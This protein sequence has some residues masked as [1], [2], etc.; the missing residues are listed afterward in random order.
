MMM[1]MMMSGAHLGSS[2]TNRSV[3]LPISNCAFINILRTASTS[4]ARMADFHVAL[5]MMGFVAAVSS[6][7]A[8]MQ[9]MQMQQ[10]GVLHGS[11]IWM[12]QQGCHT[13]VEGDEC[14]DKVMWA[15]R[16]GI[17]QHPE[18]YLPLTR[19]S[20]FEDFQQHLHGTARL[21]GVCPKPCAAA[22]PKSQ[23]RAEQQVGTPAPTVI[24]L[25]DL[26]VSTY[27]GY[28]QSGQNC[29][30]GA[31]IKAY[32]EEFET[33]ELCASECSLYPNCKSIGLH[34]FLSVWKG[35]CYLYD[36]ECGS[37]NGHDS[38]TTCA[39]PIPQGALSVNFNRIPTPAP[40]PAPTSSVEPCD[41]T[42]GSSPSSFYPCQCGPDMCVTNEVCS[43]D[44]RGF[45]CSPPGILKVEWPCLT[46]S[47]G[48][49]YF[50]FYGSSASGA[51]V[52]SNTDGNYIYWDYSC[53]GI[54]RPLKYAQ[55]RWILDSEEPNMTATMDLDSD[56]GCAYFG[57]HGSSDSNGVP[58]GNTTW[59]VA[60]DGQGLNMTVTITY[61][62]ILPTPSPTMEPGAPC[63]CDDACGSFSYLDLDGDEC[64]VEAEVNKD[65]NLNGHFT[66]M[67][68]NGD[69]CVTQAEC[70][71]SPYSKDMSRFPI[72]GPAEC[73]YG[74]YFLEGT[75]VCQQCTTGSTRRRRSEACTDCAPGKED[76]GDFDN[77][78]SGVWLTEPIST[79]S[80]VVFVNKA[81]DD[82]GRVLQ[83]GDG[84][85]M[86]TRNPGHFERLVITDKIGF[87]DSERLSPYH[88]SLLRRGGPFF[89][90][91]HGVHAGFNKYDAIVSACSSTNGVGLS[92]QYP[93]GCGI[94]ICDFGYRC[95]E[96]CAGSNT[97]IDPYLGSGFGDG[98]CCIGPPA[99]PLPTPAPTVSAK[100]DPHLVN[101]QGEHF[102]VNHGGE[103]TLLRIPQAADRTAEVELQ[104]TIRPEHGKPC[105]TYI[106]AVEL[107]GAW[108]GGI[109]VQVRSY[110][111]SHS[112]NESDSFL[113][114][115]VIERGASRE[116]P[117]S[118][119]EDWA[120]GKTALFE[121]QARDGVTVTMS[122]SQWRTKKGVKEGLPTIAGEL[123]VMMQNKMS[124]TS[125][126]IIVRQDLPLQE[127]LNLAVRRLSALGRA[128]IGGL[129]GFDAHAE[130]L[131]DVTPECQRH[132]DG[133][134]KKA[135]PKAVPS[136]KVRWQKIKE[137]RASSRAPGG[138]INDNEAGASLVNR[139][140]MCICSDAEP[141]DVT[142]ETD[143]SM[144][145]A[146]LIGAGR[147]GVLAEFRTARLAEAT[148]D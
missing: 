20:S 102:D 58:L 74:Y 32:S 136:W 96:Q 26:L 141:S 52:Y 31:E 70:G 13:S 72:G 97:V 101:L 37:T 131:E 111:R 140:M 81:L 36:A 69:G 21:S 106:T 82:S 64:L 19:N 14:F 79:G 139:D 83:K 76:L 129:L 67:D 65:E 115:R 144:N 24:Q 68:E 6:E 57:H 7:H 66:E 43:G 34:P 91:D 137:Q 30:C 99:S 10:A 134:D 88:E 126:M 128:D 135:G 3:K 94:E 105:T 108:F 87:D 50:V 41:V 130:S 116:A 27:P 123:Q 103:F 16:T 63:V 4:R 133:L 53:D 45:S 62:E 25:D 93:C 109:V 143:R 33:L 120:D 145:S 28:V 112:K 59:L 100:G 85:T 47:I 51:P 86:S 1:M 77:C 78:I 125:A 124:D 117:W 104:A 23:Q 92:E 148:W 42:D 17:Q 11:G 12:P 138:S 15:M 44:R 98:G 132:R 61:E 18:Y 48:S 127:H 71:N 39:N 35:G 60:C 89:I 75:S 95:D 55:P 114:L 110:L 56:A 84:I 49:P 40:T 29:E 107:S 38:N 118:R 147:D 122:K 5:C 9:L 119:L 2:K 90:L 80:D 113:G 22:A 46:T 142:E 146:S 54:D 121:Q 73:D 8:D